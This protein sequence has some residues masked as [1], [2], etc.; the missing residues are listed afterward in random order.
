MSIGN[1][2]MVEQMASNPKLEGLNLSTA[3][4]ERKLT[5]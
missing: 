3:V 2:K 4:T 1:C 5:K